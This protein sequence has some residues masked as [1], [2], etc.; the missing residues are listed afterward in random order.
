MTAYGLK[1]MIDKF[2]KSGSFDVKCGRGRKAIVS[3]SVEDDTALQE[4]LSSALG[5]CSAR[6]ISGTL[7]IHVSTV[8]KIFRNI[9]L[10]IQNYAYVQELVPADLPK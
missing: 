3:T 6:R 2:E 8:R 5:T 4:A 10:S 1:K 9:L 7:D